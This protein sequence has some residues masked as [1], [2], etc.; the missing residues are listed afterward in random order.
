MF[1]SLVNA[2]WLFKKILL[3]DHELIS[4]S[5][6]Q[7]MSREQFPKQTF[8]FECWSAFRKDTQEEHASCTHNFSKFRPN[9]SILFGHIANH[10]LTSTEGQFIA[11]RFH[12]KHKNVHLTVKGVSRFELLY[13]CESVQKSCVLEISPG[14][15]E[16]ISRTK[17]GAK[18]T[19]LKETVNPAGRARQPQ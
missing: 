6:S 15:L 1:T 17:K 10:C 9:T 11:K 12:L 16:K 14:S 2:L 13:F 19:T 4:H 7:L 8:D 5:Q 3:N 18:I